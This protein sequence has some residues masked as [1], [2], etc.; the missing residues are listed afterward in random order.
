MDAG[1][2]YAIGQLLYNPGFC[3]SVIANGMATITVPHAIN[4]I[5]PISVTITSR[6][7]KSSQGSGGAGYVIWSQSSDCTTGD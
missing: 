2:E 4:G 5:W 3:S 6:G 7:S 1:I